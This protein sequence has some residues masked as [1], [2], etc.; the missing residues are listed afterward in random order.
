[1][2]VPCFQTTWHV[3]S[4]RHQPGRVG[5]FWP[6]KW[7]VRVSRSWVQKR[8]NGKNGVTGSR[9]DLWLQTRTRTVKEA[10]FS[11]RRLNPQN[12]W[13]CI[14]AEFTEF[15]FGLAIA[16]EWVVKLELFADTLMC[17]DPTVLCAFVPTEFPRYR[18]SMTIIDTFE[19]CFP[20]KIITCGNAITLKCSGLNKSCYLCIL[21]LGFFSTFVRLNKRHYKNRQI[22][23]TR[24]A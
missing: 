9:R 23:T 5:D 24:P 7:E 13:G 8:N 16:F 15:A 2:H 17:K 10:I 14:Y 20:V 18:F 3:A 12:L 11:G 22:H 6:R 4:A 19:R 21:W 1:M